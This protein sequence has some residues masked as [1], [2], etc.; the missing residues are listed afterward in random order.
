MKLQVTSPQSF[1]GRCGTIVSDTA[2]RRSIPS[3]RRLARL[4]E[5]TGRCPGKPLGIL[6]SHLRHSRS[7]KNVSALGTWLRD[8]LGALDY[9]VQ[10]R[11]S[12]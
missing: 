8:R 11:A 1:V 12:K 7:A 5:A 2:C 10:K 4:I 9:P 6:V 3:R